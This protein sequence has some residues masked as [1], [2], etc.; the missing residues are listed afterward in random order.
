MLGVGHVKKSQVAWLEFC[1]EMGLE[2][3]TGSTWEDSYQA[4][5]KTTCEGY[6]Q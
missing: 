6:I 1:M 3:K 2:A 4:I 5:K